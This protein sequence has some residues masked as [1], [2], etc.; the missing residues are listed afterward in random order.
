MG[1]LDFYSQ[2]ALM[3]CSSSSLLG[4]CWRESTEKSGLLAP[5]SGNEA[6]PPPQGVSGGLVGAKTKHSYLSQPERYQ[7]KPNGD[8][9]LSHLSQ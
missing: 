5:L 1:R 4:S 3:E 9:E 8:P 2:L 6:I 7:L